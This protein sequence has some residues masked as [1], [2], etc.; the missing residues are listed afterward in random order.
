MSCTVIG[1]KRNIIWLFAT[2]E[3]SSRVWAGSVLGRP[4][5]TPG[6]SSPTSSAGG[7]S[8]DVH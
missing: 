4:I 8:W 1:S 5:E 6:P 7:E 3:V 2:I